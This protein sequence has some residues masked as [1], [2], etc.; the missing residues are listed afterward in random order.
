LKEV[1]P[2]ESMMDCIKRIAPD[3]YEEWEQSLMNDSGHC[4]KYDEVADQVWAMLA[5][6][7]IDTAFVQ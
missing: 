7:G 6:Y 1:A 3:F 4:T 5:E 2:A